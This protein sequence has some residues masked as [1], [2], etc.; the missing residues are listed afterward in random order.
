[1]FTRITENLCLYLWLEFVLTALKKPVQKGMESS[2]RQDECGQ[3]CTFSRPG[4]PK[5]YEWF[6]NWSS[7]FFGTGARIQ[8]PTSYP[9]NL[10]QFFGMYG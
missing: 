4:V 10:E 3:Q 8:Y 9:L 1:M 7:L 2:K 5:R 6:E